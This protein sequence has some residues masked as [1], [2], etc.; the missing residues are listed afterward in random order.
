MGRRSVLAASIPAVLAAAV[1]LAGCGPSEETTA[2]GNGAT[3]VEVGE[4]LKA[5]GAPIT[6]PITDTTFA[7]RWTDYPGLST[8][9]ETG[10]RKVDLT[11]EVYETPFDR[12]WASGQQDKNLPKSATY[13]SVKAE[14]GPILVSG[15]VSKNAA[16][17]AA[18]RR[19]FEKI[20]KT[21]RA[22]FGPC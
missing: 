14:C 16:Q 4:Q 18:Q 6:R 19:D 12:N 8:D 17:A 15:I 20:E 10:T 7:S 21:L 13:A 22:T 1:A 9:A 11:I 2:E 5:A 3:A